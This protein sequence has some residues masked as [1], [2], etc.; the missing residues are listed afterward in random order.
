MSDHTKNYALAGVIAGGGMVNKIITVRFYGADGFQYEGQLT[1]GRARELL[2]LIAV[3]LTTTPEAR[4]MQ[5]WARRL[6]D[7]ID[8]TLRILPNADKPKSAN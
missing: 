6:V 4:T 7:D 3:N 8:E 2:E 1:P 5:D